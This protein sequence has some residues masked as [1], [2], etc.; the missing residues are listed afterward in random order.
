MSE[1]PQPEKKP[2][3]NIRKSEAESLPSMPTQMVQA[4]GMMNDEELKEI[5]NSL[6]SLAS[7]FVIPENDRK[8][9]PDVMQVVLG[10]QYG[11]RDIWSILERTRLTDEEIGIMRDLIAKAEHGIGI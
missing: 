10:T 2:R 1:T 4:R 9:M 11:E 7:A 5:R 8:T 3:K 6:P